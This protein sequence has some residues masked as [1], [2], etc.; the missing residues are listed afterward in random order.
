VANMT[1]TARSPLGVRAPYQGRFIQIEERPLLGKVALR[2]NPDDPAFLSAAKTVLGVGL[3]LAPNTMADAGVYQIA[4]AGPDEWM[5]Y[6]ADGA[7]QPLIG[8]LRSGF[9]DMHAAVVDVSDYYT[10]IRLAGPRARDLLA[11]GCPLDLHPRV[12]SQ[13]QCAGSVFLKAT[14]RIH[15]IDDAPVFDLQIRW[16][17]ADYLWDNL[18]HGAEEW[19]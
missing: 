18:V 13:G 2:G 7:Q 9:A 6:A 14:T 4:W 10:V 17:F 11:K 1:A 15:C 19:G 8:K 16:S 12:F 3:P 5:I